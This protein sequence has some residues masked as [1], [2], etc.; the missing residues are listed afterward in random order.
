LQGI[1]DRWA[2]V[3]FFVIPYRDFKD[4]FLISEVDDLIML[5]EDDQMTVGT[6]MGSKFVAE[7]RDE[8]EEWEIKL[9]Y[10]DIVIQ[11]WLTF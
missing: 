7:I 10:I 2:E 1:K 5:L 8:V 11:E 3:D 6:M 4:K 9:K